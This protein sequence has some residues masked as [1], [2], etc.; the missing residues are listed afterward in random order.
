ML[1]VKG[2]IVKVVYSVSCNAELCLVDLQVYSLNPAS[3]LPEM[4]S[5]YS[6]TN[7]CLSQR[8]NSLSRV[9]GSILSDQRYPFKRKNINKSPGTQ[10]VC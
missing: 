10:I 6:R 8:L 7:P 4:Y 9:F 2:A 1:S 3:R 5:M